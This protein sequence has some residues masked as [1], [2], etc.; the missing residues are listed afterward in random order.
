MMKFFMMLMML[1]FFKMKKIKLKFLMNLNL[2]ILMFY[3]ML[4]MNLNNFYYSLIY[5]SFSFD[6]ISYN[7]V[8]LTLWIINLSLMS[9]YLLLK[10]FFKNY[11]LFN[12]NI[13]LMLLIFCFLSMNLMLFYIFFEASIIPIVLLIMGWGFQI[14]RIQSSMYML[15]YT[16]FGSLPLLLML[17]FLFKNFF[18]LVYMFMNMKVMN[19]DYSIFIYMLM[20]LGFLIKMPM[21][22][23]HLWLPKAHVEAPI[24]GS[25][26]LAGIM[27]KLGSY[28]LIRFIMFMK[29]MFM[30][31]NYIIINLSIIGGIYSSIIC[32]NLN[33]YKMI[34][35]YSSIVHMS[36]LM[37]SMYL[38]MFGVMLVPYIMMIAPWVYVLS[39]F[40]LINFIYERIFSRSMNFI[41]GMIN[42]L[43]SISLLWFIFCVFNMS[44]PP[45]MN[46]ISEIMIF[47]SLISW[48]NFL[49]MYLFM[50]TFFSSCYSIFLYSYIFHGKINLSLYNFYMIN[51]REY[52][53]IIMPLIPLMFIILKLN[54]MF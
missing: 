42:I 33:D 15:F 28:G 34:V 17:I 29:F 51:C 2:L 10:N 25:M 43:P 37:A 23:L 30:K 14:D 52:L 32:L 44:A 47:N 35:A 16:L 13:L 20:F 7:L 19:L 26:I 3:W 21:Y 24:S 11:Y 4:N 6:Y 8:M 46:L 9:N 49:M 39:M 18:S 22:F 41:K 31:Y 1:N 12:M 27:L 45:S 48:F 53:I 50:L 5:Y 36:S 40:C 38:T 54:L